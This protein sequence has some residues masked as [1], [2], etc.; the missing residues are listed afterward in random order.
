MFS[1]FAAALVAAGMLAAAA[2]VAAQEKLTVWWVKGFYKSEDDALFAAI[3]KFEDKTR[4]QGRAVAVPGAGH[5]PEDGGGAR[6]RHAARRRLCRRLRLPGRRQVGV[7]RQ[8]RGHH[9]HHH[10]D[11]G[12]VP[13]EHRRDDLPLQRQDQEEGVLRVPAEAADDAHPVLEGHAG[14]TRATRSPT[15]R[16]RWKAYWDFWCD[17]VQPAHRTKTGKRTYAIGQPM[18]VDSSDSFYSFLTFMD[19]YNVK[20]VDDNGKLLVDDPKV[21]AGPDQRAAG[22]H[23]HPHPRLHAAVVDELEGPGQQRVVPQQDDPADAQRDDLDRRQVARRRQQR[24]A[25][26]PSS[27]RRR[28]RTT[29]S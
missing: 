22:L 18:G 11:E 27:A 13:Q 3:K 14:A 6:R 21:R 5:D 17:K 20:L 2:P 8:A 12:R 29:T 10:A 16:P 28:R 15:S 1:K 19:A 24:D 26:A 7:R 23:E 25:D 4:R 9:G